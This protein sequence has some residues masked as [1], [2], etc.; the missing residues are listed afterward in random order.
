MGLMALTRRRPR[1]FSALS[2][3]SQKKKLSFPALF[4]DGQL[5]TRQA[6]GTSKFADSESIKPNE[7]GAVTARG[8]PIVDG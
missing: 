4:F 6:P 8:A 1:S 2:S 3:A 7:G 5:E